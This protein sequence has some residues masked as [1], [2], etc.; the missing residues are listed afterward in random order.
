MS[1]L[2][3]V[4]QL[5]PAVGRLVHVSTM[6]TAVQT[7]TKPSHSRNPTYLLAQ[8]ESGSESDLVSVATA[9]QHS[10]RLSVLQSRHALH[11]WQSCSEGVVGPGPSHAHL[12][13]LQLAHQIKNEAYLNTCLSLQNLVCLPLQNL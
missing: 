6:L 7:Y 9:A 11:Q 5:T 3:N 12:V 4:T 2:C 8:L 10:M 1:S 13:S